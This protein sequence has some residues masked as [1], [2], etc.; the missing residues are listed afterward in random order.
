MAPRLDRT[1]CKPPDHMHG[2]QLRAGHFTWGKLSCFVNKMGVHVPTA[3]QVVEMKWEDAHG[4]ASYALVQSEA[5]EN[6]NVS[7]PLLLL[8]LWL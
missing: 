6:V 2:W 5:A 7:L 4:S 1:W 8:F 3:S